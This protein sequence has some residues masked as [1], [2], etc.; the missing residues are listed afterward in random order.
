M[1]EVAKAAGLPWLTP[2]CLRHQ[3]ITLS[4]ENKEPIALIKK[5]V[6][7][8]GMS[9]EMTEYYTHARRGTQR[10]FV[11]ALDPSVRFGPKKQGIKVVSITSQK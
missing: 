7:H 10:K 2:H 3:H 1:A 6:G 9:Q 4:V 8:G 11:D 5:R